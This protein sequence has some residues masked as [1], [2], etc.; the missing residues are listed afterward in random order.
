VLLLLLQLLLPLAQQL[1][2]RRAPLL[3]QPLQRG[4]C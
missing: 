1:Q 2:L 3:L 4:R